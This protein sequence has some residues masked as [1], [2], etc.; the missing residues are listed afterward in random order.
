MFCDC[1]SQTSCISSILFLQQCVYDLYA[2]YIGPHTST[3]P[4][5]IIY[6]YSEYYKPKARKKKI[7]KKHQTRYSRSIEIIFVYLCA[8]VSMKKIFK[9]D[10]WFSRRYSHYSPLDISSYARQYCSRKHHTRAHS[11]Q[12]VLNEFLSTICEH[13]F[14]QMLDQENNYNV[15]CACWCMFVIIESWS[16]Q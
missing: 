5:N 13:Q 1:L 3:L 7:T 12:L 16:R 4:R 11:I 14:K 2:M 8:Y 6:F 10:R 9:W 15:M